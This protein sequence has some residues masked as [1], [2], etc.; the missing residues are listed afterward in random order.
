MQE[1]GFLEGRAA[2]GSSQGSSALLGRQEGQEIPHA[3][4]TYP[5]SPHLIL[6]N[7]RVQRRHKG[8]QRD[9]ADL[10]GGKAGRAGTDQPGEEKLW[11]DLSLWPLKS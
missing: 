8:D 4:Q 3:L 7:K 10:P 2:A 1:N 9:G 5:D 6:S 11:G